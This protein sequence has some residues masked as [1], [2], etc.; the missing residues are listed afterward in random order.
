MPRPK[1]VFVIGAG[2]S[3]EVGLPIGSGLI[4]TIQRNVDIGFNVTKSSKPGPA[5]LTG[6][7]RKK[8]EL[9]RDPNATFDSWIN[10]CLRLRDG[11]GQF[12]LSIDTYL[13]THASDTRMV[14]CGK[15]AIA[16]AIL[17]AESKSE[18]ALMANP[19]ASAIDFN[20]IKDTWYPKLQEFLFSGIK[21]DRIPEVFESTTFV[22]FNYD[23]CLEHFLFHSLRGYFHF[24]ENETKS[25]LKS[26]RIFHPYGQIGPLEWQS[27]KDPVAFGKSGELDAI[28]KATDRIKLFTEQDRN[29]TEL[30][31]INSALSDADAVVFLGFSYQTQNMELLKTPRAKR[32]IKIF[33]TALNCSEFDLPVIEQKVLRSLGGKHP[34]KK[35]VF[36]RN[37]TCHGLFGELHHTLKGIEHIPRKYGE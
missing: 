24:D 17:D 27:E 19:Y 9:S 35:S 13:D 5:L 37:W 28:L 2:A 34:H 26:A 32:T 31:G 25:H 22:V 6:A 4:N 23:R 3:A 15:L 10:S 30:D 20:K 21:P 7:I 14:V 36:N 11:L 16:H 12:P 33:G 18:L 1:I 29:Q 8:F